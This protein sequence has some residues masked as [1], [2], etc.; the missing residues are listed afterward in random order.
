M[1][2][3]V[4]DVP[5]VPHADWV[6]GVVHTPVLLQQ[7]FEQDVASHTQLPLSQCCPGAHAGPFPQEHAPALEQLS[8]LIGSQ[9]RHADPP[10]PQAVTDWPLHVGPEQ[11]P[12]AQFI[13]HP[14]HVPLLQVCPEGQLWHIEPPLPQ[15]IVPFPAW[16]VPV[17]SQHPVGHEVPS[18]TQAPLRHRW[19]DGQAAFDPHM[20]LPPTHE[21]AVSAAHAM[22]APPPA[23]HAPIDCGVQVLWSSQQPF[24]QEVASHAH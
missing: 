9:A 10:T 12:V 23:P 7:P 22:H 11:Q 13:A 4:Q 14:L 24:G 18:H 3:G 16:Q 1:L 5:P 20:H 21:S 8:V 19:P 6:G 15:A 17:V 2:H